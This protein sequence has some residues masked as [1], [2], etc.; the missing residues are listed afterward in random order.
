MMKKMFKKESQN[1]LQNIWLKKDNMKQSQKINKKKI[2]M[3]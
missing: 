3:Y 2:K 1:K